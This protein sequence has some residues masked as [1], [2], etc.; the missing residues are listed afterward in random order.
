MASPK[1]VSQ[2]VDVAMRYG[3][4]PADFLDEPYNTSITLRPVI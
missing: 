3:Y 1:T 2:D 4:P